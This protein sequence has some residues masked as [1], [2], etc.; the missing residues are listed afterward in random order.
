M[1]IGQNFP[2]TQEP[3]QTLPPA[4]SKMGAG[5]VFPSWAS[6]SGPRFGLAQWV[7]IISVFGS[8]FP[9]TSC[10]LL[11]SLDPAKSFIQNP[12]TLNPP[13]LC[14]LSSASQLPLPPSVR[15]SHS[16]SSGPECL[17]SSSPQ[18]SALERSY[19]PPVCAVQC[20]GTCLTLPPA[21]RT[22]PQAPRI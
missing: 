1:T 5:R 21:L 8:F 15:P 2:H 6:L 16:L 9:A 18:L 13:L 11:S 22:W 20:V 3:P 12:P 14:F 19:Q 10:C 17:A 7:V 4:S